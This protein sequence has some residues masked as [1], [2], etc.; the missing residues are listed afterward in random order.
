[1]HYKSFVQAFHRK[2]YAGDYIYEATVRQARC[3]HCQKVL[4]DRMIVGKCPVCAEPTRGD[5]CEACGAIL[6][7]DAVLN[8]CCADCGSALEFGKTTQLFL[9]IAKLERE[10]N[11]YLNAHP[12]WRKN[13]LA[14]TKRYIEEGLRD[15]AVTRD[16]D[17]GID[18]P[19]A[20]YD[21]KRIYIWAENVLGY[22]S[23]S[24]AVCA[25]RGESWDELFGE[26]AH[27][28]YVHGKDNI[29]FHTII[30]PSLLLGHG[31][32]LR[33]P[34]EIVSSEYLT[35][36]GRKIS[37]SLN[38]AIW[39]KDIVGRYHPD[40]LRYF[41]LANGPERRDTDFSWREFVARS[42]SE[43]LGAY[44]NFVNR[45]LAFIKKYYDSRVPNGEVDATISQRLLPV[46]AAVGA[47]IEQ[48][49]LQNALE[50]VLELVR[51]GNKY[52]DGE[53]PWATR[54][55]DPKHC[56][57]TLYNCVQMI[58]NL[59]ALLAPFLPFSSERVLAWLGQDTGWNMKRVAAGY[60]LP[61][62]GI[63]FERLDKSV[64]DDELA[65]LEQRGAELW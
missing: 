54:T 29:P 20:G 31:E 56:A 63:L 34:D 13:A 2:L 12:Q 11:D 52:F 62:I 55:A 14:F 59:A 48:A 26:N 5:Q 46:F 53:R 1:L 24:F 44:G 3:P 28:Y 37:T 65:Q 47:K 57:A 51:F 21:D 32:G 17:W 41:F 7:A 39:A 64:V 25:E 36:E 42:N 43:L 19:Q 27:H 33:L 35:L 61:E 22:L 15:R 30:L 9:A 60:E 18:V 45:S 50:A 38:W 10:L 49:H 23:A 58:A 6:E 8:A 16:L 40:A 4:T